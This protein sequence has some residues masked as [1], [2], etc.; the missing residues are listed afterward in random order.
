[1][2]A[3]KY[4]SV[5][6]AV[7]LIW[8]L[9]ASTEKITAET[10][11]I[12]V[13]IGLG[14]ILVALFAYQIKLR[15]SAIKMIT[16]DMNPEKFLAAFQDLDGNKYSTDR[17]I[18]EALALILSG[19]FI[20]AESLLN[21]V[22]NKKDVEIK[23][24]A[25]L[26]LSYYFSGNCTLILETADSLIKHCN[27]QKNNKYEHYTYFAQLINALASGNAVAPQIAEKYFNSLPK[28]NLVEVCIASYIIGEIKLR[29]GET[30]KA[31]SL[32]ENVIN[33]GGNSTILFDKASEKLNDCR[34]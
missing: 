14:L 4:L 18:L 6:I 15:A 30:D 24:E 22:R 2:K 11:S 25:L 10:Y 31:I 1:M 7:A 20:K 8:T 28:K 9:V 27:S 26:I 12:F 23:A 3:K 19:N 21:N 34:K 16:N 13:Y 5:L 29:S 33:S 32:F 17:Y